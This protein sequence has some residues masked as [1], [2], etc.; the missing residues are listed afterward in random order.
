M[1]GRNDR[2]AWVAAA[3]LLACVALVGGLIVEGC[4]EEGGRAPAP[5][6]QFFAV[7]LA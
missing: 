2:L 3:G 5:S 4:G 7:A 1:T 6:A